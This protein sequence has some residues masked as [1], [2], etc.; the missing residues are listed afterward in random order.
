M[1]TPYQPR[2]LAQPIVDSSTEEYW[3]AAKQG[4]LRIRRCTACHRLHWYPRPVC[5]FCM[6]DTEWIDAAGEGT[7]Y[8]VSVTRKAG[9]VA[10]ALSYVTLAEGVT[11]LTNIVDC[12]LDTLH[13]GQQVRVVFVEA[14]GGYKIPMFTPA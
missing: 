12:D 14:E 8:S 4:V 1:S 13:I 11:L 10:Y 7:I 9:P 2:T 3:N 6:G 5:P